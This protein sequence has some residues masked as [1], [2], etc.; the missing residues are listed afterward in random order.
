M[1]AIATL[2]CANQNRKQL[3]L[4]IIAKEESKAN[5]DMVAIKECKVKQHIYMWCRLI[6]WR[7]SHSLAGLLSFAH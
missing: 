3:I 6:N 7:M 1:G 5:L 2:A 4:Q